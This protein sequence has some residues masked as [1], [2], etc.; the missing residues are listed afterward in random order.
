MDESGAFLMEVAN[1]LER[2]AHQWFSNE[3]GGRLNSVLQT[4]GEKGGNVGRAVAVLVREGEPS[5]AGVGALG[6][7]VLGG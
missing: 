5:L 4:P 6:D 7:A 3:N 1:R 2:E